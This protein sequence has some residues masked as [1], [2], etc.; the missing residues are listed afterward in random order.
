MANLFIAGCRVGA[1]RAA[2]ADSPGSP[3]AQHVSPLPSPNPPC[4]VAGNGLS[5]SQLSSPK[6]TLELVTFFRFHSYALW[7]VRTSSNLLLPFYWKDV[8][9]L[10]SFAAYLAFPS[11]DYYDASDAHIG[12]RWTAHLG[13]PM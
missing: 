2:L 7:P 13:I 1:E 11:S 9:F 4:Q 12:H 6:I 8:D 5:R 3:E 10:A